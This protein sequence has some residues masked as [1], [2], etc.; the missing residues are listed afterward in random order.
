MSI[1][2]HAL[3]WGKGVGQEPVLAVKGVPVPMLCREKHPQLDLPKEP[4]QPQHTQTPPPCTR[5]ALVGAGGLQAEPKETWGE[6]PTGRVCHQALPPS[7][8]A[9]RT[10]PWLPNIIMMS[11]SPLYIWVKVRGVTSLHTWNARLKASSIT[12]RS[13]SG[14]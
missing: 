4:S 7:L 3:A 11:A 5:P 6:D 8:P 9:Q 14:E 10:S 2:L 1:T 12:A 13:R